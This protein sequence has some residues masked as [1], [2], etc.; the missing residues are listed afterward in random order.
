METELE[1]RRKLMTKIGILYKDV[2]VN[3]TPKGKE[4]RLV[5]RDGTHDAI[6][7]TSEK[8]IKK[9]VCFQC[10]ALIEDDMIIIVRDLGDGG[11]VGSPVCEKCW[12]KKHPDLEPARVMRKIV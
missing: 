6:F 11:G 7:F 9:I 5:H 1:E 3:V 4:M 12:K 2:I 8:N 10:H